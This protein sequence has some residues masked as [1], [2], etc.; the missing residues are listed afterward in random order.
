[1]NDM[2]TLLTSRQL[3]DLLQVDRITIYRML[4]DGRLQGFK[5]GGQWRFS[6]QA[7]EQWLRERQPSLELNVPLAE[8]EEV[9]PSPESL[10]LNCIQAIQAI[11]SEALGVGT[12]TATLDG[13]PLTTISNSC[14]FCELILGTQAGRLR[15]QGS[16]QR[17]RTAAHSTMPKVAT[18]HAGL[19]YVWSHIIVQGVCVAVTHAGQFLKQPLDKEAIPAELLELAVVTGLKTAALHEALESVPVLG[20]EKQ[21]QVPQLLRRVADTFSEIGEERLSFMKRLHRIA[22]IT[23]I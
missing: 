13:I 2:N 1:M 15:C 22:E 5:V 19:N 20:P 14:E 10:P 23:Q 18:C 21:A 7:I 12:V 16:W 9:Q 4:K 6:R 8:G 3:Q 11:F 17:A